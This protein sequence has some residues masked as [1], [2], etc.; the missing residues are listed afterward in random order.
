LRAAENFR[1]Q[2][3]EWC[4]HHLRRVTGCDQAD[5]AYQF[6]VKQRSDPM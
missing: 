3:I 2:R 4:E 6:G 5:H 1:L